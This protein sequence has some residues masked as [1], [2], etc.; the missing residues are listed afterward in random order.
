LGW[1]GLGRE[2]PTFF[3]MPLLLAQSP[4]GPPEAPWSPPRPP[5]LFPALQKD[6][7]QGLGWLGGGGKGGRLP[8]VPHGTPRAHTRPPPAP[9]DPTPLT[10]LAQRLARDPPGLCRLWGGGE[11]GLWGSP[12]PLPPPYPTAYSLQIGRFAVSALGALADPA[13]STSPS[14][15][16]PR[17]PYGLC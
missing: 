11:G 16:L 9:G 13:P 7:W 6:H 15:G 2:F 4:V 3:L 8:W 10:P 1:E 12:C 14:L 5:E 17:D